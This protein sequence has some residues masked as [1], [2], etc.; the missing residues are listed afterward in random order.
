M[1]NM[2]A[3]SAAEIAAKVMR[4]LF[5]SAWNAAAMVYAAAAISIMAGKLKP[6]LTQP[7]VLAA[8]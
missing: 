7:P 3:T 4:P 1:M 6:I 8:V 2:P 5:F